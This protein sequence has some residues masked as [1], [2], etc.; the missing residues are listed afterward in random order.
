MNTTNRRTFM[1]QIAATSRN[2]DLPR[3]IGTG[4]NNPPNNRSTRLF[5]ISDF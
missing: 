5:V 2:F 3:Q 4:N 1:Q